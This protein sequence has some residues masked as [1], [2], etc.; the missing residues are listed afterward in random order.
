MTKATAGNKIKVNQRRAA[1]KYFVEQPAAADCRGGV[2]HR[3]RH[4]VVDNTVDVQRIVDGGA[5]CSW[6]VHK[7]AAVVLRDRVPCR[8]EGRRKVVL[9]VRIQRVLRVVR[10]A[11]IR[12]R[13]RCRS[14]ERVHHVHGGQLRTMPLVVAVAVRA[15][16]AG[17]L[18]L[19]QRE[20][21]ELSS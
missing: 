3:P 6:R 14:V 4:A 15:K 16:H 21:A 7:Y 20:G 11:L 1:S 9:R 13:C 17:R 8:V 19:G 10:V 5:V 12:E 2:T 18:S